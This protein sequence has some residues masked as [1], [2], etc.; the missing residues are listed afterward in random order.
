VLD[1]DAEGDVTIAVEPGVR[2][3]VFRQWGDLGVQVQGE[4]L[5]DLYKGFG[6]ACDAAADRL[7]AHDP[8][9]A[10]AVSAI[11]RAATGG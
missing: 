11:A 2:V 3:L 4:N 10:D 8:A 9:A 1:A 6:E 5:P 7:R